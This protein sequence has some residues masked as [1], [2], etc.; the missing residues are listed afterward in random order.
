MDYIKLIRD[1]KLL[2]LKR[3]ELS[4]AIA[5][6]TGE[7]V[8]QV[9]VKIDNLIADGFLFLDDA[10]K[11]S[12][13]ADRGFFKAKLVLNKKGYGFAVVDGYKDF[14]IPAF[15]INGAFDGDDCLVE[16]TNMKSE[17]S[18][19]GKVV[20]VLKRNTTHV[21]GTY[22]VGKSK[23]VVLPDDSKLPQIRI[24]KGNAMSAQNNEKVWVEIEGDVEYGE[25]LHGRIIEILGMKNSP[26]AEQ[27]SII[28]SHKIKEDFEKST[29]NEAKNISQKVTKKQFANRKDFTELRTITIDGEDARDF[30]DAI[31]VEQTEDGYVLYVHI[32]DVTNYVLEGSA[33]DKEARVRGTSVYFPNQVIPMLPIELSNGICSLNEGENRLTV[34]VVIN[35]D[36]NMKYK[37]AEICNS[38]IKSRHRM[39]YTEIGAILKEDLLVRE[40]Y[41]D[42][43]DDILLYQRFSDKLKEE[44]R[45]RGEI[46]FNL[47]EIGRA[48]V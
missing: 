31:S 37:S 20:K 39:T 18:I 15:N 2:Y 12:V 11:I 33:I 47:P 26:K 48:H 5:K 7:S 17:E 4:D 6:I 34:S 28:R 1:N 40:K 24:Y 38:V 21:V 44:R 3:D 27:L 32:A 29:L 30:D 8:G 13:C 42:V 9:G 45:A 25:T 22:I 19:E 16:I 41:A 14:F 43:L 23:N 46:R 35:L 36:K 10:G